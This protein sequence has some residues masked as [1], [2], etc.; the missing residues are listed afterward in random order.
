[1]S[2]SGKAKKKKTPVKP[3]GWEKM[4]E[5]LFEILMLFLINAIIKSNSESIELDA[6]RNYQKLF[7][8]QTAVT[9]IVT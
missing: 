5:I 8:D 2:K 6:L 4:M 3:P 9:E 1:M 7:A